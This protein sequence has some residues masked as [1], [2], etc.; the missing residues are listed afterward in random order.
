[1]LLVGD[2]LGM[3][4]KG[5]QNTLDVSVEEMSYHVRA[6]A[7]GTKG[8]HIVG[9]MPFMSYQTSP[10]DALRNAGA[11]IKAGAHSVKL[12][13]G[14]SV[15]A[16]V[17]K[18]VAAGIPVVGHI[19]LVP[20]S[21]NAMGGFV[22]QGRDP[23]GRQRVLDDAHALVEAGVFAI[24]LEGIPAELA[25]EVTDAVPVPTIGI[26][27]G[28]A[29]DGQVLVLYDM[30]GLNLDFKPKFVKHFAP[31]ASFVQSAVRDYLDDVRARRFPDEEHSFSATPS[32]KQHLKVASG[33]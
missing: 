27:A 33:G 5:E 18:I 30:L 32:R 25:A 23:E 4:I 28:N 13:G 20:Q 8:A 2:S 3:V 16:A 21:V 10:E 9:D 19:G 29:C 26:G 12:E 6:V 11:L 7:R 31:G 17:A 15:A 14:V 22:V 24:V 1:M